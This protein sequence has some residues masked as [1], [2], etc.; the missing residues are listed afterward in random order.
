M[1]SALLH[2]YALNK[3]G[4]DFAVG[5]LHGCYE[6]LRRLLG[7]LS[8]DPAVDRLFSVGDLVDRGPRSD[9]FAECV[10]APWFHA[11]RG[12]H[13]QLMIDAEVD[14]G[15]KLTWFKNGGA[16][17]MA[18]TAAEMTLW[19]DRLDA[20]PLAIEVETKDGPVGLVHADLRVASWRALVDSLDQVDRLRPPGRFYSWHA[21]SEIAELMWSRE[22]AKALVTAHRK[23]LPF[24]P[25]P[26]LHA[27]V[28]GHTPQNEALN[29]ANCWMI[30]TGAGYAKDRAHLTLLDL[31]TFETHT[32][33]T[34]V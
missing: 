12:N 4:R 9:L 15:A 1:P 14:E 13:D 31:D 23:Q 26:D 19:R 33:R 25:I 29:V 28:M 34:H 3:E 7:R 10:D 22:L 6:A 18:F 5:D 8:F 2:R 17:S 30:D 24:A 32:E 27:L 11:T 20:L 16:W 21:S